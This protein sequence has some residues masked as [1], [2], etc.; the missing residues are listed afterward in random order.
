MDTTTAVT[1]VAVA[2]LSGGVL[3]Y[4]RDA[5]KARR[6]RRL[7]ESPE[8]RESANVRVVAEARDELAEDNRRL[9][10]II[11]EDRVRHAEDR[12][13]WA[14]EKAEMRGEISTLEAKVRAV[15]HEV[16]AFHRRYP[17]A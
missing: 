14:R 6:A 11:T 7:A 16:E 15:L 1:N 3:V 17:E 8:A 5:V 13:E 10:V 12:A 4:I 2:M 9:R